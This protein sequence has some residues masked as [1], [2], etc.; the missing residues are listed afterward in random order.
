MVVVG[1]NLKGLIRAKNICDETSS[2]N[3]QSKLNLIERFF[4]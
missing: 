4:V 2:M 3:S 1:D